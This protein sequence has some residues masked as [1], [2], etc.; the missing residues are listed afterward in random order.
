MFNL[1]RQHSAG[2]VSSLD[3]GHISRQHLVSVGSL[4]VKPVALPGTRSTGTTRPL[5]GLGLKPDQT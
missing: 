1:E 2:Q 3:L 5:L 4:S